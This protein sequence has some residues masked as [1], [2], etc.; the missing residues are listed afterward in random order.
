[1]MPANAGGIAVSRETSAR[2]EI[3]AERL[4][5]WNP[6]INLVSRRSVDDLWRRHI[7]DSVQLFAIAPP[8]AAHW[9]DIGSGGGFPGLVIAAMKDEPGAPEKITLVESDTRKCAFLRSVIREAA[10]DATVLP[11][12]IEALD[13]LSATVISARALAPLSRLLDMAHRHATPD[14][15]CLFPKGR[16]WAQEVADAQS[17]WSFDYQAVTSQTEHDAVILKIGGLTRA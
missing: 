14:A 8:H 13:N 11:A 3:L 9:L 2:L 17:A 15:T 10:L 7:R 6:R 5:Q 16:T 12:R 4:R 1:M